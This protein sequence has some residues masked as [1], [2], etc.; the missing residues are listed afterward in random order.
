MPGWL[1]QPTGLPMQ[2]APPHPSA[3]LHA[4]REAWGAMMLSFRAE[5]GIT[6]DLLVDCGEADRSSRPRSKA[7]PMATQGKL[8][9]KGKLLVKPSRSGAGWLL[10]HDWAN[11]YRCIDMGQPYGCGAARQD[12]RMPIARYQRSRRPVRCKQDADGWRRAGVLGRYKGFSWDTG[13]QDVLGRAG[14]SKSLP[15]G[16]LCRAAYPS[17]HMSPSSPLP[18]RPTKVERRRGHC[19]D[20][21]ACEGLVD[22]QTGGRATFAVQDQKTMVRR[23]RKKK[24]T[25]RS[26]DKEMPFTG[27]NKQS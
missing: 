17:Q 24:D 27:L 9:R 26:V 22:L 13:W 10:S 25:K 8:Y 3:R 1:A 21:A 12:F 2:V 4:P 5:I 15:P 19:S 23:S 16:Y 14:V 20:L 11:S 6:W 7:P 18:G